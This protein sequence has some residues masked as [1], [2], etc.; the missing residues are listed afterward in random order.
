MRLFYHHAATT[1]A[2]K[3]VKAALKETAAE[4]VKHDSFI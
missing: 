4:E 2:L 3:Y 1:R